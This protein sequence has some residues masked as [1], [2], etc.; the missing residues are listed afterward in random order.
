MKRMIFDLAVEGHQAT[1][2]EYLIR[3]AAFRGGD[4]ELHLVVGSHFP[5]QY[6]G[7]ISLATE[8]PRIHIHPTAAPTPAP[9]HRWLP[10]S[11]RL[12]AQA[13]DEWAVLC[14]KATE[15]RADHCIALY[16]DRLA[17]GPLALGYQAP[18]PV[19]GILFRPAFYYEAPRSARS[20]RQRILLRRAL[21]N[22]CLGTLLSLD[23]LAVDPLRAL[24][25]KA[26]IE[27]I[28][29]PIP[30]D[31]TDTVPPEIP[32]SQRVLLLFGALSSRKG[33]FQV[34]EALPLL[35]SDVTES[36]C[37]ALVG[38]PIQSESGR[39]R[40]AVERA[41]STGSVPIHTVFDYVSEEAVNGWFERAEIVLATYQRHVGSSGILMRAAAAETPVLSSDYGLMGALTK[42]YQLGVATDTTSAP[43]ISEAITRLLREPAAQKET[44]RAFAERHTP[45][46]F[47]D[48]LYRA[49]APLH[50]P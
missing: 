50:T 39:I 32:P 40:S 34:L 42:R 49:S 44:M 23:P 35:P 12:F 22:P 18:C 17:Q 46:H 38:R 4:D 26:R 24:Q 36:V 14:A 48:A 10:G 15:L 9:W 19:S 37:L 13:L 41:Q 6:P 5:E 45:A 21:K 30:I 27:A 1:W 8:Q 31:C 47:C 11:V 25:P 33:I 43:A 7:V 3:D 29:D 20:M 28:P 2:Y 16:L